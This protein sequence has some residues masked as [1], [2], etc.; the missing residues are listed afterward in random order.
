MKEYFNKP[1]ISEEILKKVFGE[2]KFENLIIPPK[3]SYLLDGYTVEYI[4]RKSLTKIFTVK[5]EFTNPMN[6]LQ[7]GI[8][9]AFLDDTIGPLSYAIVKGPI[10][11]QSL[12]TNYVRGVLANE[13]ILVQAEAI[14]VSPFSIFFEAK[15]YD[16]RGKLVASMTSQNLILKKAK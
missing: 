16:E 10:V 12:T 6:V 4:P 14:T 9:V 1:D 15:S 5:P 2:E 8:L 11:T 7:G 13:K 3:C